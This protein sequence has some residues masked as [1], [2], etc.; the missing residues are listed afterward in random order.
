MR[1]TDAVAPAG[2]KGWLRVSMCQIA[3]ARRR[4]MSTWAAFA[5]LFAEALAVALVALA[6]D[7]VL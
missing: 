1:P 4:A 2:A 7:R 6:I 5:A 3:S